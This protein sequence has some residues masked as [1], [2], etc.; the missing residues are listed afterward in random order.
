MR[1]SP[2]TT[3][4]W[5]NSRCLA[6]GGTVMGDKTI[7]DKTLGLSGQYVGD[8]GRLRRQFPMRLTKSQ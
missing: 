3:N 7:E 8:Y 1:G 2:A 4:G 5:D 6:D